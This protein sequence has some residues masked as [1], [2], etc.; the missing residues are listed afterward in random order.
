MGIFLKEETEQGTIPGDPGQ[1]RERVQHMQLNKERG[2]RGWG[3]AVLALV[4]PRALLGRTRCPLAVP[5]LSPAPWLWRRTGSIA[6]PLPAL[7]HGSFLSVP[8]SYRAAGTA[9][10]TEQQTENADGVLSATGGPP[11]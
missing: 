4:P 5:S 3:F 7:A 2:N 9:Q 6:L 1:G 11:G 8:E 10:Q